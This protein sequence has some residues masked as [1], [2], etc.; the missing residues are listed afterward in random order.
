MYLVIDNF[1]PAT[2]ATEVPALS[3]TT[4]GI[5]LGCGTHLSFICVGIWAGNVATT[6]LDQDVYCTTAY[7]E[8]AIQISIGLLS[9]TRIR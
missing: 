9:R 5:L 7:A 1:V 6:S 2:M 4:D 3:D 8:N